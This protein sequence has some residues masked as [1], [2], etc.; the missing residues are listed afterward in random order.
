MV[1][2]EVANEISRAV[3]ELGKIDS[4]IINLRGNTGEE[5]GRFAS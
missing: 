1:G 4:L 2:V 5:L 3:D